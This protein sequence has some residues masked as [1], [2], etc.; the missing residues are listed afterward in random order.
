MQAVR[1]VTVE[2][3]VD[4]RG[5]ALVAFGGAGPLHACAIAD[6]LGMP[7]VV[8]PARAGVLS[9]EG[10]ILVVDKQQLNSV[11]GGPAGS[12]DVV[13]ARFQPCQGRLDRALHRGQPLRLALPAREGATVVFDFQG[14]ARHDPGITAWGPWRL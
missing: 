13:F 3:G 8:V 7:A 10:A 12:G 4:P 9:D 14:I 6:A 1:A 5:L 2:R 11:S